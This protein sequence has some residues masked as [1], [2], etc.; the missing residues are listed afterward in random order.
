[1]DETLRRRLNDQG[2][3]DISEARVCQSCKA[4][5]FWCRTP[6]G[7]RMPLDADGVSHFATCPNA[8]QHRKGKV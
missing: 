3:T 1:M 6:K 2:Y 7:K 4:T 8:A 5:V